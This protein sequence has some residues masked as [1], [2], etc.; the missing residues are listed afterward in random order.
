MPKITEERRQYQREY[1]EKNREQL[2]V[3]QREWNRRNYLAKPEAHRAR[4]IAWKEAN[5]ERAKE[6]QRQ[7]RDRNREELKARGRDWY[8]NNKERA[9]EQARR[10]K[11]AKYGLTEA[12]YQTMVTAQ[13]GLCAICL[14]PPKLHRLYVD[15]CH[16]TGRVRGLLCNTCN[17]AIG[18]L[19]DQPELLAK[20]IAY[21]NNG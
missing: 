1:Y 18:M 17:A 5:P 11:L 6:L 3:K 21:L 8:L 13:K 20:A 10:Q 14:R 12:T 16:L 4:A 9:S 7:Y 15:H 2:L 19:D